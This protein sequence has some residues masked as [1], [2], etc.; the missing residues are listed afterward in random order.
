MGEFVSLIRG[1]NLGSHAKISMGDLKA[2]HE[3]LGLKR[4]ERIST[5]AMS[6]SRAS[7]ATVHDWRGASRRRSRSGWGLR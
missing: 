4:S 5:A 7:P 6:Y 1:I 2:V 3:S